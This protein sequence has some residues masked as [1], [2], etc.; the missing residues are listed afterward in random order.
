MYTEFYSLAKKPFNMT[1]D[2]SFLFLTTQHREALAGLTY[3]ILERKG[4]LVLSGMAGLGKTTLLAWVLQKLPCD[5]VQSS[6]ILNPLLTRE[7][8]LELAMLDFGLTDIPTSKAQRLWMLQKFLLKGRKEGKINVLIVDE[9]HKLSV[10]LLEEIRLLGN[11][12]YGDEK[13]IQILLVG[14]SELDDVMNRPDL[15]QLKQRISVRLVLGPLSVESVEKYILHRWTIAGGKAPLPF[16]ADAIAS[17]RKCSQGIPR[18]I[19]SIC[20]N[21]L[22]LAF[23]DEARSVTAAHVETAAIDLQLIAKPPAAVPVPKAPSVTVAPAPAVSTVAPPSAVAPASAVTPAPSVAPANGTG[24]AVQT[25][26]AKTVE[27]HAPEP[28]EPT[29][30]SLLKTVAGKLGWRSNG[31]NPTP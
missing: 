14:Q 20:D 28:P 22:T 16:S 21:A 30:Q 23:A 13:L 9:A 5:H 18:L 29:K 4:F 10:E 24:A 8:F 12:E 25:V 27:R 2:P 31:K 17:I 7:E 19:N 3:A 1:P 26:A 11:L 15:W 6:V